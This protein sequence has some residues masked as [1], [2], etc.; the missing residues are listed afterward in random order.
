MLLSMVDDNNNNYFAALTGWQDIPQLNT[1]PP[2]VNC[3]QSIG[4]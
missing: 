2:L 1:N 3:F 4:L